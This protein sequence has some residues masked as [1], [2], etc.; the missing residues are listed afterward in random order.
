MHAHSNHTRVAM[1]RPA[2]T[3]P[4]RSRY[5]P[6]ELPQ[7]PFGG[8]LRY[9]F[10]CS[11]SKCRRRHNYSSARIRLRR[12]ASVS[13]SV[14]LRTVP[15]GSAAACTLFPS[16][17]QIASSE[18]ERDCWASSLLAGW[19]VQIVSGQIKNHFLKMLHSC[20]SLFRNNTFHSSLSN[21]YSTRFTNAWFHTHPL[22]T[23][24]E[25]YHKKVSLRL[26]FRIC[27]RMDA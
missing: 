3:V 13:G 2:V 16:G 17:V 1:R 24:T 9:R 22:L 25:R 19:C 6:S 7:V 8:G 20:S 18:C 15:V 21:T 14:V 27:F 10:C 11:S 5:R 23:S 26:F 4:K 12:S